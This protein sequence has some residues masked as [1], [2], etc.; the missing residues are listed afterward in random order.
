MSQGQARGESEVDEAETAG[1]DVSLIDEMLRLTPAERL[2]QNDRMATLAAKL[3]AAFE[4][5]AARWPSRGT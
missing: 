5:G 4:T 3:R 2:R 1:V